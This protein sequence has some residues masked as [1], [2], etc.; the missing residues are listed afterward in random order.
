MAEISEATM[1]LVTAAAT[2][3]YAEY[4]ANA[5]AEHKAAAMAKLER[6]NTDEAYKAEHMGRFA[7]TFT[8]ADSNGDGKLV[9]AEYQV[10]EQKMRDFKI[11]DG[12]W[13]EAEMPYERNYNVANSVSEGDGVT[14]ADMGAVMKPWMAKFLELKAA[15]EAQ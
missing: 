6:Y 13:V 14:M 15:D 8:E 3:Q 7:T 1:A 11:A 4:K 12:D 9:L 2:E 10:F 5:T